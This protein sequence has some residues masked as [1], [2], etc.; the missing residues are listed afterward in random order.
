MTDRTDIWVYAHWQGMDEPKCIG[1]LFGMEASSTPT[2]KKALVYSWAPC[3]I[4][5]DARS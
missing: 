2:E 5:G 4:P 3:L 1:I